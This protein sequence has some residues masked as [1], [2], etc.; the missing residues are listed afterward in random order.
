MNLRGK[1]ISKIYSYQH[2][3]VYLVAFFAF[4]LTNNS[5]AQSKQDSVTHTNSVLSKDSTV[6][7]SLSIRLKDSIATKRD[8]PAPGS[9]RQS[10]EDSLGI[11]ISP[12]ALTNIVTADAT[13]SAVLN[14]S[15]NIF[16]L[17]GNAKVKY[18]DA[19]LEAY[20]V[21]YHQ[22]SNIVTAG[23][24]DD[25]T[26][27]KKGRPTFTQGQEKFTYDSL[28]YNFKSKRAI[29]RNARSQYGEGFVNSEQVKRNPDQSIYGAHSV[30]TTCALEKP[31]FGINARRIKV[32]PGRV[33]ASGSANINI[34]G[35]PTPLFLPFGLF[36]VSQGQRSGFKIPTFTN[37]EQRGMGLM[38]GG[39]YFALSKKIDLLAE[40]TFY[41]KGSWGSNLLSNY[42]N[43][44]HYNG[45]LEFRYAYNKLGEAYETTSSIKKDFNI[46]WSHRSD[47]KSRPGVDFNATVDAGTGTYN[48]NNSYNTNQI[49]QNQYQSNITL[50]KR[51]QNKPHSLSISARHDQNTQSKLVNIALPEIAFATQI[52]PFQNKK[53][54]GTRWYDKITIPYKFNMV[55]RISFYDTAFDI[56]TLTFKDFNNAAVHNIPISATYTIARFIS[57]TPRITYNEYWLTKRMYKHY[58]R[59]T[60]KLDTTLYTGFYTARDF[61]SG[62]DFTTS[63]YGTKLFKKGKLAGIRHVIY[64]SASLGYLP[65]Y[66][67]EPFNYGYKSYLDATNTQRYASIYEGTVL[68]NPGLSQFGKAKSAVDFG[69][70]NTLQIKVRTRD[71]AGSKN[72]HIIDNFR[73]GTSYN[74][75]ADSFNWSPLTMSFATMLFN[76]INLNAGAVYDLYSFDYNTGKRFKETRWQTRR[77]I[78]RFQ[79]ANISLGG[80][81]HAKKKQMPNNPAMQTDEYRRLMQYGRYDDYL[82]FNIPFNMNFTYSLGIAKQYSAS[83]KSDT[84]VISQHYFGT[85]ADFN[86]TSRWKIVIRSGY[87]F[88]TKQLQLTSIDLVRDL[89]CWEMRFNTVPFGP[90]KNYNF[91]LQVKASV[92]QDL[93]L[94]RRRDYRDSVY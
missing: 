81:L 30:Y 54:A 45:S 82:D 62:L 50:S 89:H 56:N 20:E 4:V 3:M 53:S 14:M 32:I 39:Y 19:Q 33:I 6:S 59:N 58:N 8:S 79:N 7:D 74:I 21:S 67:A 49:L 17:Y 72:I 78:G 43:R 66:A 28:Q 91:T 15:D 57:I 61:S 42:A 41:S 88:N 34:E 47:P 68:G 23:M 13:D 36:P 70:N 26:I 71:S 48:A 87:D 86:L 55:N 1:I 94:T 9:Q 5:N 11:R 83:S 51:W 12:D 64:P 93:K 84:L 69:L 35:I 90:R 2:L 24:S 85:D 29:V 76:V 31:H 63:I 46:R 22:S 73:V 37:E 52:N 60:D 18:E 65:D 92:L 44:Y 40:G 25:T 38:N 27:A 10:L 75:T 16:N 77:G 80:S